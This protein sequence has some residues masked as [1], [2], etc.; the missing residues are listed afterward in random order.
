[1]SKLK[2]AF[3]W[4]PEVAARSFDIGS[5]DISTGVSY[6]LL[7]RDTKLVINDTVNVFRK[8]LS[9]NASLE[10]IV[11]TLIDYKVT[12]T[13]MNC[14]G[15]C[16]Y[17]AKTIAFS[18]K[19]YAKRDMQTL[20]HEVSHALQYKVGGAITDN[21]WPKLLSSNVLIEQQC[22]TMAYYLHNSLFKYIKPER[23]DAYFSRKDVE[24]LREW[25]G[26]WVINDMYTETAPDN[27]GR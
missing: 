19:G 12:I 15:Y 9:N 20:F 23:F 16:S 22:E 14:G 4:L 18:P 11:G 13:G 5:K 25:Y 8:K 27:R 2:P 10:E 17:E 7:D 6:K 26:Q 21:R 24:F 3:F 1:M